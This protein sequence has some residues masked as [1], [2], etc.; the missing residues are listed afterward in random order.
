MLVFVVVVGVVVVVVVVVVVH[1]KEFVIRLVSWVRVVFHHK[2]I[3]VLSL[4]P[5]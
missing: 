3:V 4:P 5:Q 1:W 2:G